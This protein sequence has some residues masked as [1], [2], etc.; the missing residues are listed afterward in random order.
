MIRYRKNVKKTG[1]QPFDRPFELGFG[2][3][4]QQN[5]HAGVGSG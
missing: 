3:C 5:V 4:F 2:V 1:R